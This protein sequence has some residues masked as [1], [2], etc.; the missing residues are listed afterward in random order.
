MNP[1][2]NARSGQTSQ[3]RLHELDESEC[4][5][6]V[7][8]RPIGRLAYVDERGPMVVPVT[9]VVEG[10]SVLFRVAPY[11]GLAR[12]VIDA[13]SAFEVD[14][15]DEVD[16]VG[17]SVVLRG[18]VERV[19]SDD[20]PPDDDRPSPWPAGQRTLYLRLTPDEVTGRRLLD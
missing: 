12:H 18:S 13:R 4:W 16:R 10:G 20:L 11:S 2:D 19:E 7:R 15:V 17:W 6:L 9:F 14:E 5:E 3:R 8:S 1:T